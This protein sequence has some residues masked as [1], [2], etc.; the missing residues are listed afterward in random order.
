VASSCGAGAAAVASARAGPGLVEVAHGGESGC[1]PGGGDGGE[2][3]GGG[4]AVPPSAYCAGPPL[5]QAL[6]LF[7]GQL[8]V[9][10]HAIHHA[11]DQA[12]IAAP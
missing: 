6:A 10:Q 4:D 5:A 12:S 8:A 7:D 3:G 9:L 11:R 1:G 2:G